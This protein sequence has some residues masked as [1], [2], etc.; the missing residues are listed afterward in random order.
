MPPDVTIR[1]LTQSDMDLVCAS[2]AF[3]HPAKPD[4]A[5][6]FFADANHHIVGAIHDTA[7]IGFASGIVLLHPDKHPTLFISEVG[8]NEAY[9]RHGIA[10]A[11]VEQLMEVGAAA[12][13]QGTWLA[14]E[15][16]NAPA[17]GLYRK[18]GARETQGI[19]VY[20]WGDAGMDP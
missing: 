1:E 10:T 4:Q 14:T 16:D 18:T 5:R 7:L 17:R 11:L 13:C 15:H 6:A 3:D 19:V 8:V 2:E 9:Q 20:D 12:G